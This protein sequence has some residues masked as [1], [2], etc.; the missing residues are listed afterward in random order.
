MRFAPNGY[1][2]EK[3]LKCANCGVL[4]SHESVGEAPTRIAGLW[5]DEFI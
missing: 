1:Y 5:S 3:Y 2:I 4:S